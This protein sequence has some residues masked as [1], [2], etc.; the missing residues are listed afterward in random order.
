MEPQ[1]PGPTPTGPA[2]VGRREA[3]SLGVLGVVGAG[4]ALP[5]LGGDALAVPK[6]RQPARGFMA[7]PRPTTPAAP[8]LRS[9]K[10]SPA[11]PHAPLHTPP[12]SPPVA[13]WS[14]P[15][16]KVKDL[17]PSAPANA[18]A[19]TIDDGPHPEYTPRVLDLLA[20][21]DVKA[22]FCLIGEQ[23]QANEKIVEMMH[24]AGHE[25]AN[26]TWTHP[27]NIARMPPAR[28]DQEIA[29]TYKQIVDV[30]GKNPK[31][32][33]SPGGVWSKK[34]FQAVARHGLVPLDWDNDPKDWTKPGTGH[35]IQAMLHGSAGDILLCHDG[36]GDRSET[37]K[38]LHVV[39]PRLK[40]RGLQFV[41]L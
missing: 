7:R 25:I 24:Q 1:E 8:T 21:Y 34:V 3:L 15:A 9:V 36:G 16:F 30:T 28:V 38:A 20:H 17:L 6:P 32:F 11:T 39:V 31:L 27:Y 26:H 13:A 10:P 29:K 37:L 41:T 18:I 14:K 4:L 33:R 12:P 23:I 19:L 2:A 5:T 40:S 22:T 35:I